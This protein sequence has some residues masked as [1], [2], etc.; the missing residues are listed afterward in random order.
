MT[1]EVAVYNRSTIALAADSAAT[2]SNGRTHKIY[3]NAE[4]LFAL[5]KH[6]PVGIMV[7]GAGELLDIPWE[8]VIKSYRKKLKNRYFNTLQEYVDDFFA[9][10]PNFFIEMPLDF[11]SSFIQLSI[12]SH[13]EFVEDKASLEQSEE[14]D[15]K[16][17]LL[18]SA[19]E[20]EIDNL[21]G[22]DS[23]YLIGFAFKDLKPLRMTVK[24]V[25]D[26]LIDS[27]ELD[28]VPK[29]LVNKLKRTLIKLSALALCTVNKMSSTPSG[30]VFAG[31][32][33]NEYLPQIL[34][35]EVNGMVLDKLRINKLDHKCSSLGEIAIIPFAQQTEVETFI[36]GISNKIQELHGEMTKSLCN[37]A[38]V[39]LVEILE[40]IPGIDDKEKI[41]KIKIMTDGLF[42]DLNKSRDYIKSYIQDNHVDKIV[43]MLQHLPKN[44]LAYMAESLVNLTAFKRKVSNETDT[45]GGPI[46]VAVISK[47]D[48]FVWVKRKHYYPSELNLDRHLQNCD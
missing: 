22:K 23:E 10:I 25:V 18:I 12:M 1:A 31:Y 19:M 45:V 30:L 15:K 36:Q 5:T 13:Y 43:L 40:D 24:P 29:R 37:T 26:E 3:N 7:Y 35:Y 8:L 46:D 44:E 11:V 27:L 38:I 39:K 6:Y 21:S 48:G 42:D 17:D 34:T 32:G 4:K 41:E 9:F 2:I 20:Q 14:I 33:E 47:G 28:N 16:I